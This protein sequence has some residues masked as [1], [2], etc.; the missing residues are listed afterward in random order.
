MSSFGFLK[1]HKVWIYNFLQ[2]KA[3]L[4]FDVE[5]KFQNPHVL[6]ILWEQ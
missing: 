6:Q 2:Y 3:I 4:R 1:V 5:F